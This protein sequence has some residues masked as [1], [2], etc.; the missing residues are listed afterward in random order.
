MKRFVA[1]LFIA[2]AAGFGYQQWHQRALRLELEEATSATGFVAMP[3]PSNLPADRV[4]VLAAENCPKEDARRADEL[5]AALARRDIPHLRAHHVE[6]A[7]QGLTSADLRRINAVLH[8][9]LPAVLVKG[10]GKANPT[11]D[12]VLAEYRAPPR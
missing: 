6:F 11:L 4:I 12:E 5:A 2:G 9:E 3:M 10:R 8:G 7:P 1:F